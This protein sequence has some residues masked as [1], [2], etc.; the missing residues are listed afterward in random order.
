[1]APFRYT[2]LCSFKQAGVHPE[3]PGNTVDRAAFERIWQHSVLLLQRGF[4]SGSIL[5]VDPEEAAVLG[6]PWTRRCKPIC[7]TI[8]QRH[9]WRLHI[10]RD[11]SNCCLAAV[12]EPQGRHCL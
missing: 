3:Q 4:K 10:G 12:R 11:Q 5:T 2:S 1:M 8:A 9:N 6:P 7:Y